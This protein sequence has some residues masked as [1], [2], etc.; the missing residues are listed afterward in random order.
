MSYVTNS[1]VYYLL[2]QLVNAQANIPGGIPLIDPITR[3]IS[4]EFI[5]YLET[6]PVSSQF[7]IDEITGAIY[8]HN[9]KPGFN[10]AFSATV[11]LTDSVF[12]KLKS[13][14]GAF[15]SLDSADGTAGKRLKISIDG[16]FLLPLGTT[17]DLVFTDFDISENNTIII[18]AS[19]LATTN[20]KRSTN[21][22]SSF[23]TITGPGAYGYS[24]VKNLGAGLWIACATTGEA[25]Y[26]TDDGITW[27]DAV[28]DGANTFTSAGGNGGICWIV[29]SDGVDRIQFS[30]DFGQNYTSVNIPF[31][32]LYGF[33]EYFKGNIV[34]AKSGVS[35]NNFLAFT[36][37]QGTTWSQ[38]TFAGITEEL[39]GI[40]TIGENLYLFGVNGLLARTV[41][42]NEFEFLS[43]ASS[44]VILD[45]AHEIINGENTLMAVTSGGVTNNV[46][47]TK[48]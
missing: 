44:D 19:N 33:S 13:K 39:K 3:K 46:F 1:E 36:D 42:L 29:S 10:A 4:P 37:D 41:D 26:S 21:G 11:D 38:R 22:G 28:V 43:F 40:K 9:L 20:I 18:V 31:N 6:T 25:V 30:T 23:D 27:L 45:L 16:K 48:D 47:S 2:L 35:A 32:F 12:V 15:Y 8:I 7:D 14:N 17:G 5:S 24:A 34:L